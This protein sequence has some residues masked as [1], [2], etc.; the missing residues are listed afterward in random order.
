MAQFETWL[1]RDLA[2]PNYV[3]VL[4]HALF[5]G[6]SRGNVFGVKLL[7]DGRPYNIGSGTVEGYV[8]KGDGTTEEI[9]YPYTGYNDNRAWIVL[10]ENALNVPGKVQIS[11]RLNDGGQKTV[12]ASCTAMV[13]RTAT[14]ETING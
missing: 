2:R 6:D 9:S 1:T 4:D 10:S 13:I 7:M 5:S 8:M 3:Q 14:D 11:I 12:L